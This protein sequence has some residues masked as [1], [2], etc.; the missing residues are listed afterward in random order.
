MPV[1]A[2]FDTEKH[3]DNP[4]LDGFRT[5][6]SAT[7]ISDQISMIRLDFKKF[8][9]VGV[10]RIPLSGDST[11]YVSEGT[12]FVHESTVFP[13]LFAP[14]SGQFC[15]KTGSR[16]PY[17]VKVT[18]PEAIL[19]LEKAGLKS[20][21][22]YTCGRREEDCPTLYRLVL[23]I[24]D[25]LT[26]AG[27]K[28]VTG[29]EKEDELDLVQYTT[30]SVFQN[31][32]LSAKVLNGLYSI[33][34]GKD[35]YVLKPRSG[36]SK[37]EFVLTA[38]ELAASNFYNTPGA[39]HEIL[40]AILETVYSLKKSPEAEQYVQRGRIWITVNKIAEELL[41]TTS[42]TIVAKDAPRI[43]ELVD[44]ALS[45]MSGAQVMATSPDG[46]LKTQV[47]VLDA[48]RLE[49]VVVRGTT[50]HNVWGILTDTEKK[51]LSDYGRELKHGFSYPVAVREKPFSLD[52][53]AINRYLSDIMHEARGTLYRSKGGT[54]QRVQNRR[55]VKISRA[56]TNKEGTGIFD[57]LSS[58]LKTLT[59]RQKDRMVC[60]IEDELTNMVGEE[61][62]GERNEE[63]PLYVYA[64]C[65]RDPRRGR[66]KGAYVNLHF[67]I[68]TNLHTVRDG[69]YGHGRINLHDGESKKLP[70]DAPKR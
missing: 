12:Y 21:I 30:G 46:R 28:T 33:A 65:E 20:Q 2:D 3:S 39:S 23:S 31:H 8:G 10:Q 43:R 50:Y 32:D 67:E 58:P 11:V 18:A 53:R 66:G 37:E 47:Y 27:K 1:E 57:V 60:A 41:R 15:T 55:T 48:V 70:D 62:R 14:K 35:S 61:A 68:S 22:G 44:R 36:K 51:S 5:E 38:S 29:G 45:A 17:E 7:R 64:W 56:W 25:A 42:G 24:I 26:E 9:L 19:A 59:S 6:L 49:T 34:M 40:R 54:L 16:H 13:V 4:M 69:R 52:S 63:A